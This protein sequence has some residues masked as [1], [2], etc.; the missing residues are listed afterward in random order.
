MKAAI[1]A[2][3]IIGAFYAVLWAACAAVFAAAI[4]RKKCQRKQTGV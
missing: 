2:A 3:I 4:I 1:T